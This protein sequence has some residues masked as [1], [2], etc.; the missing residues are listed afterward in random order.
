MAR[1]MQ[2]RRPNVVA[3]SQSTWRDIEPGQFFR[4]KSGEEGRVFW[5]GSA[6]RYKVYFPVLED[7][8]VSRKGGALEEFFPGEVIDILSPTSLNISEC[9]FSDDEAA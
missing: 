3:E 7:K 8:K 4:R 6:G 2:M 9:E 5:V 1:Q